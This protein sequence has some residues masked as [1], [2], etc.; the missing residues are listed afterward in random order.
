MAAGGNRV[1]SISDTELSKVLSHALRHE[2][3]LDELELDEEGWAPLEQLITALREKGGDWAAVDRS[4]IE[5]ML[6][7]AA[8]RRHELNGKRIRALYGHS[9]AGRILK[10]E[11]VP[12]TR[13]F[14]GTDP[15]IWIEIEEDG[16]KPMGRQFVHMSVDEATARTVGLR[17]TASPVILVIDAAAAALAGVAFYGGNDP[18]WLANSVPARFINIREP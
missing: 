6:A 18:V 8:K 16:L 17:K 14:H 3:W 12:P 9:M 2:P 15:R 7:A 13:L 5:R 4:S 11:G 1:V 10:Q